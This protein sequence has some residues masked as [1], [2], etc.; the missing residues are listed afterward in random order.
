MVSV[1]LDNMQAY[2]R[3]LMMVCPHNRGLE[4]LRIDNEQTKHKPL[5]SAQHLSDF[6]QKILLLN[7]RLGLP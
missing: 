6:G 5:R 2:C 4:A 1:R 7:G 3:Q